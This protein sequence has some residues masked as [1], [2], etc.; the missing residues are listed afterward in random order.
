[1]SIRYVGALVLQADNPKGMADWYSRYFGL[2][3]TL[4][5]EGGYFGAFETER[6]PFHFGVTQYQGTSDLAQPKEVLLTLRV[7]DF[8]RLLKKMHR[9]DQDVIAVSED[10]EGSYAMIHDPE[11][12]QVSIW[13]D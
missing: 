3:V 1:M 5:H 12:N 11:G 4:E 8:D 13:G 9:E 2:E 7:D 10:D 6:G